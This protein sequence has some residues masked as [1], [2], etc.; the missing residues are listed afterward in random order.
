MRRVD[1]K[2]VRESFED[3]IEAGRLHPSLEI[4]FRD[5]TGNHKH[6]IGAG[7]SDEVYAFRETEETFVLS[8]SRK[9]GYISFEV[10]KGEEKTGDIFIDSH[11]VEET[12]GREDLSP[13]TIIRRLMPYL[14]QKK[15]IQN[16][17][18]LFF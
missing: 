4:I 17:T 9:L 8:Q 13:P 7:Y 11:Q 10:F 15:E 1:Y 5:K 18:D 3:M 14:G 6:K 2:I 16:G 12:F